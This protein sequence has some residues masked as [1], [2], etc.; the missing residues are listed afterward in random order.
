MAV[1]VERSL[2]KTLDWQ[3]L[4]LK[5]GCDEWLDAACAVGMPAA[6]LRMKDAL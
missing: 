3:L 6:N 2:A 1:V 5:G 4:L